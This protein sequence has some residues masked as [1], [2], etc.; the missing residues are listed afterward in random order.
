MEDGKGGSIPERLRTHRYISQQ[1]K[2]RRK[3]VCFMPETTPRS[4]QAELSP[5]SQGLRKTSV[6]PRTHIATVLLARPLEDSAL[7]HL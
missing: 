3:M 5:G 7:L 4:C 1:Q 6:H 2:K